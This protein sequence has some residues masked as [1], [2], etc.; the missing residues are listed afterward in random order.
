MGVLSAEGTFHQCSRLSN[1]AIKQSFSAYGAY[2][3]HWSIQKLPGGGSSWQGWAL[4]ISG[5][6][7]G[8]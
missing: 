7:L 6:R 8:T 5:E 3:C 2:L 4:G 1:D